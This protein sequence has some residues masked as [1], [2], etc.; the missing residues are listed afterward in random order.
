M[1]PT[2]ITII[3]PRGVYVVHFTNFIRHFKRPG[4]W[5]AKLRAAW[6]KTTQQPPLDGELKTHNNTFLDETTTRKK[7]KL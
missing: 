5:K 4:F 3:E 1:R 7:W 2:Y 6:S